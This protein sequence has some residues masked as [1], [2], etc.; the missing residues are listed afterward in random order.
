MVYSKGME[1][2][3]DDLLSIGRFAERSG[4]SRKALRLYAELGL[5]APTH[6]DDWTGYRYYGAAQLGAARLI[7][8]MRDMEMP[9]GEIRRVLAAA[10][11]EAE[12][13]VAA[14][15]RAFAGRLERVRLVGRELIQTMRQEECDMTTLPVAQRVLAP[16]QVVSIE[17]HVLVSDLEPFLTRSVARLQAFV[18]A[19]GGAVSGPPL[20]LYHGPVNH[21]DDGPVEVCLPAEGAFRAE[22]DVR[23]RVLPGGPAAVV[24]AQGEHASFPKILEAY[25]AGYDWVSQ[26]GHR[27]AESPREV[28]LIDPVGD[29]PFEIIWR[30]A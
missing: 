23:I 27:P 4:L 30:Y 25:D 21:E 2:R 8:L 5:L 11:D 13:L 24:T 29:G 26:N 14:H 20:G 17:A 3:Q 16:Q 7:R 19:Q 1:S 18:A 22:G 10:P 28:W 12:R 6:T 15:E 9:L